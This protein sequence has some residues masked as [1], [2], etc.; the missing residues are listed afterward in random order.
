MISIITIDHCRIVSKIDHRHGGR[1]VV[2]IGRR[3]IDGRIRIGIGGN[4]VIDIGKISRAFGIE[5]V[6][7]VGADRFANAGNI[8]GHYRT[9]QIVRGVAARLTKNREY[10]IQLFVG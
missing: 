1:V 9:N 6:D 4:A 3:I 8:G 7:H 2:R 5:G 10:A